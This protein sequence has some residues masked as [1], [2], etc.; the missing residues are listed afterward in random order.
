LAFNRDADTG[1]RFGNAMR[2]PVNLGV[3]L[4]GGLRFEV[5]HLKH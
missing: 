5:Q 2:A 1:H 4:L 3:R